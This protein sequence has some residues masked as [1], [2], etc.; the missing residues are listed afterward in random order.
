MC[1]L[2]SLGMP[3]GQ[4][5]NNQARGPACSSW[6]DGDQVFG[7][8]KGRIKSCEMLDFPVSDDFFLNRSCALILCAQLMDEYFLI[9]IPFP[10]SISNLHGIGLYTKHGRR[11]STFPTLQSGRTITIQPTIRITRQRVAH[12]SRLAPNQSIK[13]EISIV[14][15]QG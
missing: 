4:R 2:R 3:R 14:I 13:I 9:H 6:D 7:L 5:F 12:L 1:L 8:G 15:V 10:P 11:Q